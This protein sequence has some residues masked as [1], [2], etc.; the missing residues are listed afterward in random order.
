MSPTGLLAMPHPGDNVYHGQMVPQSIL[1]AL[2][3][4][5]DQGVWFLA[6]SWWFTTGCNYSSE[7]ARKGPEI[8]V[9]HRSLKMYLVY[10][11]HV[12][13]LGWLVFHL[14]DHISSPLYV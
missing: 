14:S 1:R 9:M 3:L 5:E 13:V 12:G 6:S 4:A 11:D 2:V 8:Y 7:N 10:I